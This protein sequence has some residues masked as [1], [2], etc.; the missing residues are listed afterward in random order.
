MINGE[1]RRKNK[2]TPTKICRLLLHF[3]ILFLLLHFLLLLFT[4]ACTFLYF[5]IF[6]CGVFSFPKPKREGCLLVGCVLLHEVL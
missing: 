1:N 2:R 5:E 6:F 4:F 3:L